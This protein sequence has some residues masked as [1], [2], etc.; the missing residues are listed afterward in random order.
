[1]KYLG[2][3]EII[4]GGKLPAAQLEKFL[5]SIASS[6][7]KVG[8][9]DG[10]GFSAK[11]A[12]QLRQVLNENGHLLLVAD[13]NEQLDELA[14]FCVEHG[15]VFDR[16]GDNGNICFRQGM[17]YPV[18]PDKGSDALL[19]V[20]NIR[21]L[22]KEVARLVTVTLTRQKLL[23]AATKVIRHLNSLLPPELPPLEIE[24]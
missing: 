9:H 16:R 13:R 21:P 2:E 11:T 10:E 1:M 14:G 12:E 22:A 24:E 5:G 18:S 7:A 19:D 23:A 4:I 8:G 17:K 15:I 20:G 3:G 6:G